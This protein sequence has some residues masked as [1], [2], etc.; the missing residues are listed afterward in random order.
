MLEPLPPSRKLTE[1]KLMWWSKFE[2]FFNGIVFLIFHFWNIIIIG[3]FNMKVVNHHLSDLMQTFAL[4]SLI[5]NP[6][7][8][9]V[10][11]LFKQTRKIFVNCLT[12]VKLVFLIIMKFGNFKG[13]SKKKK[14]IVGI[15]TLIWMPLIILEYGA[16]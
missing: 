3:D 7:L 16:S 6:K 10:L 11:T 13:L 9:L 2:L 14:C 5:T 15:K 1:T 12:I 4:S 8:Q